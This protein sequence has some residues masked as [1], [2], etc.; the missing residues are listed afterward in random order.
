[1]PSEILDTVITGDVVL[2]ESVLTN[3]FVGIAGERIEAVGSG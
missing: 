3:G 1:M 2:A